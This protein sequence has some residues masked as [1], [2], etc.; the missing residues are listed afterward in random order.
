MTARQWAAVPFRNTWDREVRQRAMNWDQ[1]VDVFTTF[2]IA[3]D[4]TKKEIPAWS[5]AIYKEGTTRGKANVEALSCLVLDYDEG[6][7][8]IED[9]M[10]AWSWRAGIL[11]TSWSHTEDQHRFRVILP[12]DTPVSVEDWPGVFEWA[13]RYTRMCTNPEDIE[14][15]EDYPT[16]AQWAHTIDLQCKDPGRIYYLPAV[17]DDNVPRFATAWTAQV[18][19][20]TLDGGPY[21][22][23]YSPWA[24][25]VQEHHKRVEAR[26]RPP[27]PAVHIPKA[28]ARARE[29]ARRLMHD[30]GTRERLGPWLGGRVVGDA[31]RGVPCPRCTRATV[32]WLIEP[33][34]KASASC[35][36]TNSCGW[37]GSLIELAALGGVGA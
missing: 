18:G 24:A 33:D 19:E 9:A 10:A 16:K 20:P 8:T 5:P 25:Q 11:H 17:Q 27:A 29:K 26:K 13:A 30:P 34:S 6:R 14:R 31:V 2:R 32:W 22:G 28:S 4:G 3:T 37:Y 23:T 12:L 7:T 35:N 15:L 36:H 21:L 1:L